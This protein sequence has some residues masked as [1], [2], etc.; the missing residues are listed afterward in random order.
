MTYARAGTGIGYYD[1]NINIGASNFSGR[2]FRQFSVA[3]VGAVISN[4]VTVSAQYLLMPKL[5][6]L[7]FSGLRLQAMYSFS[8]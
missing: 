7:D 4:K 5:S 8:K 6:G 3:E 2:P 1:Y